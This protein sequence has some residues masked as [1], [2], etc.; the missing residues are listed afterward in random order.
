[1]LREDIL[2]LAMKVGTELT[3]ILACIGD[4]T[5]GGD[6]VKGVGGVSFLLTILMFVAVSRRKVREATC[7]NSVSL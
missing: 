7:T 4:V 1:M 3:I 2:D 5:G 6:D